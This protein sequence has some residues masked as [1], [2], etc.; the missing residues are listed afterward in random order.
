MTET[1]FAQVT[2]KVYVYLNQEA[3]EHFVLPTIEDAYKIVTNCAFSEPD[4][5][6]EDK[7][8]ESVTFEEFK[9]EIEEELVFTASNPTDFYCKGF[10]ITKIDMISNP[11]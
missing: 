7:P 3:G 2:R 6:W 11:L 4:F 1:P 9:Q 10:S 8:L 5:E